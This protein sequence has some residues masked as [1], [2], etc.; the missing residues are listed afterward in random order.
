MPHRKLT[1]VAQSPIHG[2][3]LF[4]KTEIDGA[5][6]LGTYEGPEAKRNGSH[7]LWVYEDDGE[8]IGRRGLNKM[9]YVNHSD[10]PNAEFD[11]FDLYA[12]RK[13]GPDEEITIDY[14]PF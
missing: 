1:Y 5:T 11:G 2:R 4:A 13:I 9:R 8:V 7:V 12:T 10:E 14:D 3:G 6:Y